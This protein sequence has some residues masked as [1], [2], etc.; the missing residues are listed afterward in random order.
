MLSLGQLFATLWTI[1]HQAPL[2]MGFSRQEYWSGLP[3]PSSGRL[4][5]PGIEPMS[6]ALAGRFFTHE[7]PEKP[8]AYC[9][10]KLSVRQ[11]RAQMLGQGKM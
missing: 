11:F 8:D 4:P 6:H 9:M 5:G 3:F 10:W 2:S 7:P 1:A